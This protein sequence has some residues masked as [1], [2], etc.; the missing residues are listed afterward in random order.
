MTIEDQIVKLVDELNARINARGDRLMAKLR[1][2]T[3]S[4][5][6]AFGLYRENGRDCANFTIEKLGLLD[7]SSAKLTQ[8]EADW[9]KSLILNNLRGQLEFPYELPTHDMLKLSAAIDEGYD[10]RMTEWATP[11]ND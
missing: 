11:C 2:L 8:K 7:I 9:H 3:A 10:A 4:P 6:E 1:S 5:E